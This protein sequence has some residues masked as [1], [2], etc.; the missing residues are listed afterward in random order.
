MKA[1]VIRGAGQLAVETQPDPTPGPGEVVVSFGAGG[2]CGS[3]LHYY[4]EGGVG[5]F[6]IRQ[7]MILGHEVAGTVAAVGESVTKV[8]IGDRVA[9][10]PSRSCG[11][12]V[13]C[14]EGR[15]NLCP[16][17]RFLGSAARFPHIPGG[18]SEYILT[19]EA[20]C[21]PFEGPMSFKTA[22]CAEP[23]AV[24]LH[25]VAQTGRPL[26]G[27]RVLISGAG[28]IGLLVA[29]AARFAGAMEITITDIAQHPL[30][31]ALAEFNLDFGLNV[32][33]DAEKIATLPAFDAVFEASGSVAALN[34]AI[35]LIRPGGR[36]VQVGMFAP[37][38]VSNLL[39]GRLISREI[40]LVG[41]FRFYREYEKAVRLLERGRI[42][43]NSLL[44]GS[45]PL[46]AA[47][48]AFKLALD[49]SRSLKVS[50]LPG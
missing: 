37:G 2:I 33:D 28:P 19:S 9:V 40:E 5:D 3:D 21:V 17:V 31:V 29:M 7:P 14:R 46:S 12:C 4:K 23:L 1:C 38:P 15:P 50:L 45:A 43:I 10:N 22:S 24:A 6:K 30:D 41:T 44:T 42:E 34:S 26:V 20:Q 18:F 36:I 16:E 8:V 48:E 13:Q 27:A 32:R 25:A 49:R 11:D 47:N 35:G 39:L